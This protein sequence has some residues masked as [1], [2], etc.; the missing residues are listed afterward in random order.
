MLPANLGRNDLSSKELPLKNLARLGVA[1][2]VTGATLVGTVWA[3]VGL[4]PVSIPSDITNIAGGSSISSAIVGDGF[5]LGADEALVGA[6]KVNIAP[7]PNALEGDIWEKDRAKC[8]PAG[9]GGINPSEAL[10]HAADWRSTW[11]ENTNCIYAG[12]FGVGPSQ[13]LTSFD[14]TY[15]LW[16][17]SVAFQKG[18]QTLVL[19]ILDAE[20]YFGRYSRLCGDT[21]CGAFDLQ[22]ELGAALGLDPASFVFASTHAHSGPDLIGGWGAVPQWYMDQVANAMRQSVREA[23]ANMKPAT[24]EAGDTLAR[25]N[26]GERRDHYRSAEDPS[27]NW[28]RAIDR[29]GGVIATTGTF[30][31]HATSFGSS[32]TTAHADWPGVFDKAVETKFGGIGLMFEAGLG[33]MS[34][35]GNGSGSMGARLANVIPPVG[36][37]ILVKSPNVRVKQQFWDQPVTNGPLGTLA[38]GGF[39]DKPFGGPATVTAGKSSVKPCRSASAVSALVSVTAAKIGGVIVTAAPG[40]I[41]ANY[42]NTIE[43]RASITALAIGQANDALGYMPQSFESD[44]S[45]RQGGGFAGGPFEYEDA[46]SIDA[47]FGDMA[48]ETTLGLLGSL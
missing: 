9:T 8:L 25:E 11:I 13:P 21:P 23:V 38:A 7:Q 26:N 45:A 42:S 43:E 40:E 33:N 1:G 4:A 14:E 36:T 48:L 18:G 37:G 22:I 44:H 10:T 46:Y 35:S 17:R 6:S 47:C 27:V 2:L 41:F 20:G 30:A 24:I 5:T 15:G 3:G 31:A 32:T 19:T 28:L 12:G 16:S 34:A 29:S 39:F